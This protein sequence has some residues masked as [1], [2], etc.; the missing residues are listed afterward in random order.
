LEGRQIRFFQRY[1]HVRYAGDVWQTAFGNW[2]LKAPNL[3]GLSSFRR[4]ANAELMRFS[5]AM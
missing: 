5:V 1:A 4:S 2:L 3:S